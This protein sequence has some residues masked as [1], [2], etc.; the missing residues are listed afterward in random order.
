[1]YIVALARSD[2]QRLKCEKPRSTPHDQNSYSSS[3]QIQAPINQNEMDLQ[4]ALHTIEPP[5]PR[6]VRIPRKVPGYILACMAVSLGGFLN[7]FDTGSIG[8]IT[9]ME[10]FAATFGELSPL[11]RGFTVRMTYAHL[12]F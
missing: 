2:V 1:M 8:A 7:G 10:Q 4:T 5:G 3:R 12:D 6:H 9:D 11:I